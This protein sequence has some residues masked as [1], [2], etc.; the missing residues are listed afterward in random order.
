MLDLGLAQRRLQIQ[1]LP[2][3]N[4]LCIK[5]FYPKT[6][7]FLGQL[8]LQQRR[9]RPAVLLSGVPLLEPWIRL[10]LRKV[11]HLADGFPLFLLVGRDI[12]VA[13]LGKEGPAGRGGEVVIAHERGL[14]AADEEIG[15]HPAHEGHDA[16]QQGHVD[17]LPLP[18][19]LPVEQGCHHGEGRVE[20]AHGVADGKARAQGIQALVAVHGHLARKALD[21]LVVGGFQGIGPRLAE[22]GNGAVDESRV[23]LRQGP[24]VQAQPLHDAGAEVLHHHIRVLREPPEQVLALG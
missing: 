24:V 8:S 9:E 22:A 2:T 15:R 14:L 18:R 20:A 23:E 19:A 6:G 3:G 4:I 17:E 12:D 5:H 1:D 16:V 21:D 11:Q 10:Q 7:R 13:I